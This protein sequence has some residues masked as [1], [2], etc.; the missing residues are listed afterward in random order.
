MDTEH[1]DR[2]SQ[3]VTDRAAFDALVTEFQ[4]LRSEIQWLIANG[5]R[6][7]QFAI[8]IAAAGLSASTFTIS[9]YPHLYPAL[10]FALSAVLC[11]LGILYYWEHVEI[12]V[13]AG[14]L[15]QVVR[16]KVRMAT[17]VDTWWEWEEYKGAQWKR[18]GTPN[19]FRW[20]L[21]S[22][23]FIA[24]LFTV[25]SLGAAWQYHDDL[26]ND[27]LIT[28]TS[29]FLFLGSL[30]LTLRLLFLI[31]FRSRLSEI[32]LGRPGA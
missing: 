4:C 8:V 12:H 27:R 16:A 26:R 14:Y 10:G 2:G 17:R 19:L 11:W 6:Y 7:Q 15:Q 3:V 1:T 29:A 24:L 20:R 13:V 31:F 9:Q 30:V 25:T 32:L 22:F 28:L 5:M 23:C 18:M 21:S